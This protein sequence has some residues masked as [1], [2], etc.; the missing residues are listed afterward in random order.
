M[1]TQRQMVGVGSDRSA[2][3]QAE[4]EN[5]RQ[6]CASVQV[7]ETQWACAGSLRTSRWMVPDSFAG[8]APPERTDRC[9]CVVAVA[10]GHADVTRPSEAQRIEYLTRSV[11]ISP[12]AGS[13]IATRVSGEAT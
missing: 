13:S 10:G 9:S 2:P 7:I 8:Q 12:R 11:E 1:N 5:R 4:N 3:A 6:V